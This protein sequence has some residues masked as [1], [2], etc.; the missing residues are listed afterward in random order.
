MFRWDV[1]RA[2][3]VGL[4][5]TCCLVFIGGHA[6]SQSIVAPPDLIALD[7]NG[8]NLTTGKYLLPSLEV[9]IGGSGS[10]LGRSTSAFLNDPTST[11]GTADN[12]S[13]SA[14]TTA[15]PAGITGFTYQLSY[16]GKVYRFVFNTT[17]GLPVGPYIPND[18]GPERLT[19]DDPNPASTTGSCKLNLRD[20]TILTYDRTI[21]TYLTSIQ[22]PDGEVIS[23]N[24]YISGSTRSIRSVSSTLGWMLK[25]QVDANYKVTRVTAINTAQVYCDPA[26]SSCTVDN[27][28]PYAASTVSGSTTAIVRNGTTA[29]TTTPIVSYSTSGDVTT[30]TSPAGVTKTITLYPPGNVNIGKVW[31]V[32]IGT[33]TWTY[34]YTT[35]GSGIETVV[36]APN[37]TTR[38]MFYSTII[39]KITSTTDE[40]G[41]VTT[42]SYNTTAGD[43]NFGRLIKV[44]NPDGNAST[45]GFT[46]YGYN[47]RGDLLTTTIVPKNGAS[48]GLPTAGLSMATTATYTASCDGISVSGGNARYCHK[49]LTVTDTDGVTTTYTYHAASGEVQSVTSPQPATGLQ[50]PQTFYAY[51]QITP[52]LKSSSGTLT[53]QAQVWRLTSTSSCMTGAAG[54]GAAAPS[55]AAT[56]DA[57][58]STITYDNNVLPVS[59]T[60]KLGDGTL[61]QT[62]AVIYNNNGKAIITDGPKS[63]ELDEAYTFYDYLGRAVG[64]VGM[65]PDGTGTRKRHATWS[66]YDADGHLNKIEDGTVATSSYGTV[67]ALARWTNAQT[68]W[69]ANTRVVQESNT[70][71]F[72]SL[73]Q[74][75][76]ARHYIG[77]A[78]G[79]AKDVTQRSYDSMLRLDC[80]ADRLNSTYYASISGYA[81]CS[82]SPV[83]SDG[84]HDRITKHI[85]DSVSG[86]EVSTTSAFGTGYAR[87]DALKSYDLSTSTSSGNLSWV[88]DAKGN[89]TAYTYD[90]LNRLIKTCY[91]ATGTTHTSSTADCDQIFYRT[92]TLASS[93]VTQAGSLVSQVRLRDYTSNNANY[94]NFTYDKMGRVSAKSGALTET[95]A[96]DNF[97]QVTSHSNNSVGVSVSGT[98]VTETFVYNALGWMTSNAQPL[99][100]MSYQ[101]DAYGRRSRL[102]YPGSGLY[103]T[104]GYDDADELLRICENGANCS[105]ADV[106]LLAFTYDDY[107]Q[108][109][110]TNARKSDGTALNLGSYGFDSSLRLQTVTTPGNTVTLGYGAADQINSRTNSSGSYEP[111]AAIS[112][113]TTYG[114]DGLNRMTTAG[115]SSLGYDLRGNM[116]SDGSV[117]MGY[118]ANNLLTSAGTAT[119]LYDASGRLKSYTKGS[120][121][122]QFVYD[123]ADLIAEYDG[124]GTLLRR[125]VHGPGDDEPLVWYEGTGT[126]T[127]RFMIADERGSII[128]VTNNAGTVLTQNSYDEYGV[129]YASNATYAG[130]FRYT[131]QS[132]L[133][134][135]SLYNYKARMYLPSIGRFLQTDPI[136][137]GDG[138][139][140]YAYVHNDPI[141]SN[142]PTGLCNSP[143]GCPDYFADDATTVI[144]SCSDS[145]A[146]EKR[147]ENSDYFRQMHQ[148]EDAKLY[149]TGQEQY[150]SLDPFRQGTYSI[151]NSAIAHIIDQHGSNPGY[152]KKKTLFV[153]KS[154]RVQRGLL[155]GS[156]NA[157]Y[158]NPTVL[159]ALIRQAILQGKIGLDPKLTGGKVFVYSNPTGNIGSTGDWVDARGNFHA[160]QAT[161]VIVVIFDF[162]GNLK[163]AYTPTP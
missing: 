127:P 132:W 86:M 135:L 14:T 3:A 64:A 124:S 99:G 23:V 129:P 140:W 125:Y 24:Y 157:K 149:Y 90:D 128:A 104:Y 49:P 1:L 96:Y 153:T 118:N 75:I 108:R 18:G 121:T 82:L 71:E 84:S 144:V 10:A 122:Y 51:Q 85:Y 65:D 77:S 9:G 109:T 38:K 45:G 17:N 145:A 112:G 114:V 2:K 155:K 59:T 134:E 79:T 50:T 70:N 33:S 78:T 154:G 105:S 100:T 126:A 142:D 89:R 120:V 137:Y 83:L 41:R 150:S 161:N 97:S 152:Q 138:M 30:I 163:T 136:G 21:G 113:A 160:S 110:A 139:N 25:Y 46:T 67:S 35:S 40:A 88:E 34:T 101:Y 119:L 5:A 6:L 131:G 102:T 141:N 72:N 31:K 63:G 60:T 29:S 95:F 58:V 123:G 68:D 115:S 103:V 55:C 12:F 98:A 81:A 27:S 26:A 148:N 19:C 106:P 4:V 156:F 37:A 20:A 56:S 147:T 43:A 47:T 52:Y 146:C 7:Q 42:Y 16:A 107:G 54:T 66:Y 93:P 53:A 74:P 73:G 87:V 39:A 158:R 143:G 111:T 8:V 13:G 76:I 48:G 44:I 32:Q 36:T 116:I 130:R 133:P 159:T 91:P 94:I 80:E 92:S 151:S 15:P 62:T 69:N 57:S 162:S 22:K 61:A 117:T 11:S 28:Y